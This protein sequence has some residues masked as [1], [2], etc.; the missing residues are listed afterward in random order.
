MHF[1][2]L[3]S[4]SIIYIDNL[5]CIHTAG[6]WLQI[7]VYLEVAEYRV[8]AHMGSRVA[9]REPCVISRW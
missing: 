9:V 6:F 1:D 3:P 8:A 2:G 7:Y 5:S 4:S